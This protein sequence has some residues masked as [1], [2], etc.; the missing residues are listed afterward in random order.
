[1]IES[2]QEN[3]VHVCANCKDTIWNV[4]GW[5]ELRVVPPHKHIDMFGTIRHFC[6][7]SCMS[8]WVN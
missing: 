5:Y 7:W 1:M 8:E 2:K 3:S 4:N 6:T